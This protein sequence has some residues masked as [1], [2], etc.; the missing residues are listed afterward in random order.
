ML[1]YFIIDFVVF[2]A[3]E[4]EA[5][6]LIILGSHL[7]RNHRKTWTSAYYDCIVL[8]CIVLYCIII[9]VLHLVQWTTFQGAQ[10][11]IKT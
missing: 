11:K 9:L 2:L 1:R 5:N 4:G 7:Q 10:I 3:R 6:V 8:Y